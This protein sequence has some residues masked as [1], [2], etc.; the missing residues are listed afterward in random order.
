MA[1][2]KV[3]YEDMR[4]AGDRLKSGQSEIESA[5]AR[6][7]SMI[8]GLVADGYV[9]DKSSK[10]FDSSYTEFNHG[11]GETIKGLEGMATYLKSAADTMEQTDE[12]L[13]S[14]LSK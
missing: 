2:I 1:N 14:A 13:A 12:Q 10:A 7:K 4:T 11:V 5:L 3:T 8:D 6:L 9:T